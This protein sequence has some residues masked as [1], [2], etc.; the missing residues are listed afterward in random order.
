M[1]TSDDAY[2]P[3]ACLQISLFVHIF[4]PESSDISDLTM[5]TQR[6]P[7][8]LLVFCLR[9][10]IYLQLFHGSLRELCLKLKAFVNYLY[11]QIL[12][13]GY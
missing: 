6:F 9:D 12:K 1:S 13:I 7:Q 11:K 3:S 2:W 10:T 8:T 5:K 4:H